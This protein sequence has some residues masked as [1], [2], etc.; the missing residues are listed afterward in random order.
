MHKIEIEYIDANLL[1]FVGFT[2]ILSP[3]LNKKAEEIVVA[4]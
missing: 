4:R 1:D 2:A 3:Q